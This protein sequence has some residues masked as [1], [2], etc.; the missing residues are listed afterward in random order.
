M[1]TAL[2]AMPAIACAV[3][4]DVAVTT[5]RHQ[6]VLVELDR[7]SRLRLIS[8]HSSRLS[9]SRVGGTMVSPNDWSSNRI[10]LSTG[11]CW[12][13]ILR[14]AYFEMISASRNEATA[15]A[16]GRSMSPR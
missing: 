2:Q 15:V 16:F 9:N 12:R 8:I 3:T 4:S 7:N 6:P 14:N 11:C 10:D 1:T 5:E 13:E